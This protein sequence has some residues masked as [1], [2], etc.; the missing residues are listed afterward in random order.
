MVSTNKASVSICV[1]MRDAERV[2]GYV[3]KADDLE[4]PWVSISVG[5]QQ[6]TWFM[7]GIPQRRQFGDLLIELGK[8]LI[9]NR[10]REYE[11][12]R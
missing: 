12:G 8:A 10:E 9:S 1:H 6:V 5:G 4:D 7:K 3:R 2:E 11:A